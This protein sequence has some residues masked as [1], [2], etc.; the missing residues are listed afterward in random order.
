VIGGVFLK[1]IKYKKG[2]KG[3]YKV[4]LEDGRILS[5]Y[6]E[7]ILKTELLL[8]KDIDDKTFNDIESLNL[9]Y[10]VYYVA[11]NS[12]KSRYKSIYDLKCFLKKKEYPDNLI[13]LAINKLS[14]QG[15]LND[16]NFAKA[17]INNQMV[18]TYNGPLKI[19]KDLLDKKI[20]INIINEEI[21]VFSL[22]EQTTKIN[23]LIDKK[24]KSNHTR[25][26]YILKQKICNDLKLL[27]YDNS[28]IVDI[29]STYPFEN[30]VN[31]A[32]KEYDKLFKRLSKKYSGSEL[33]YK[34]QEKLYQKGLKYEETD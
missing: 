27:G 34:I 14:K 30:D 11:L 10:E 31:L 8:K 12:I 32:K 3:I 18:T 29:I 6:E 23:K 21:T 5:L 17:Y 26:G 22:E 1:I 2:S 25:G 28:L 19:E 9:Q 15:Y 16:R 7:V 24:I 33:E 4:E 13:D 20:D